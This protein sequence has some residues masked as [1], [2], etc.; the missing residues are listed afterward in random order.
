MIHEKEASIVLLALKQGKPTTMEAQEGTLASSPDTFPVEIPIPDPVTELATRKLSRRALINKGIEAALGATALG[1]LFTACG[2]GSSRGPVTLQFAAYVD[3]TGEQTA[4]I[5]TFNR[6][7][8]GK[9]EVDYL[10]LPPVATDQYS[11]F[12]T[13]FQFQSSTPDIVQI[14]VTWPA[15]FA[16]PGW[17]APL[18]PYVTPSYLNQFWPSARSIA[19]IDGKL[20][21]IQRYMDIGMLYYRTDLVQKYGGTVPQ[22]RDEMQAMAQEILAGERA[23]GVTYGY[24]MA[25]KKIEAIV[26]EWLEFIWGAGGTIGKPGSLIINGPLQVGALQYMY[27][28]IYTLQLA[29]QETDT[30]APNDIL[31]LFTG[32]Q[33]PFMRN[34]VYAYAIANTASRSRVAG[35]V[36]VAPTLATSGHA[37]HGCTGG[38]VLAINAFSQ[39]KDEAWTFIDYLLSKQTQT[40]LSLNAGLISSRPDVVNDPGV[41]ARVPYFKQLSTILANGLNRPKLKAYNQFTT[42]LQAAINGVLDNQ[43]SPAD[44]LNGVQAQVSS[45]T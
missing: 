7:H 22:T 6:M 43:S 37:G 44:A 1:P 35:K 39:Y 23:K 17:L 41:Q 25:G 36:G 14:D 21:G 34:W 28:L 18:D 10:Q 8:A 9:I 29:P 16:T 13:T 42:Q 24:V 4:E 5:N 11:K 20:Y 38:W 45:L 33:V 32:G 31:T 12:L 2:G 27:D 30:Y 40:S 15:Q 26:D 19:Q 3:T